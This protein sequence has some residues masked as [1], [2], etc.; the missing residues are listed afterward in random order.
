MKRHSQSRCIQIVFVAALV[1]AVA[2]ALASA[3]ALEKIISFDSEIWIQADGSLNVRETITVEAEGIEIKR[4]I[5]RDFP[6][7]YTSERGVKTTT[8]FDVQEVRR[9]GQPENWFTE[10]QSNGV[11]LYI[12]NKEVFLQNGRYVYEINYKTNRQLGHFDDFDELYWNVTGNGWNF[13]IDRVT[14]KIH[15]P[16]GARVLEHAG[17]TGGFGETGTDFTFSPTSG[18]QVWFET[19][20]ILRPY[21]GLTVAVSWP[22]GFVARPTATEQ[23]LSTMREYAV[24]IVG[25]IGFHDSPGLL[26]LGLAEGRA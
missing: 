10:D 16:E 6:T 25:S 22:L 4:G 2:G 20:R 3:Q 14:A 24:E 26:H 5:F 21:E 7:V 18:T 19:T 9:D 17:Y 23:T 12:G 1:F 11:R 8:T 13:E 15:L